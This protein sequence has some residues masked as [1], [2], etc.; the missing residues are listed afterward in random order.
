MRATGGGFDAPAAIHQVVR[1]ESGFGYGVVDAD[2]HVFEDRG[3]VYLLAEHSP[4]PAAHT[5]WLLAQ[6]SRLLNARFQVVAFTGRAQEQAEL[7]GWRDAAGPRL[8]ARWLHAPGGQGKTRLA[9]EFA[10]Q[11]VAAGWKVVTAVHGPGSILPPPGSQ[12]MRIGQAIGLLLIVD[13]AD[14]WPV[15]HLTWLFS[16]ALL[17]RPTPTRLLLLGRSAHPWPAVRA[18][19][20]DLEADTCDQ[21]LRPLPGGL[22]LGERERMF[23]VARDC[24][25][26]HYDITDPAVITPPGPLTHPSF[27][28][29]LTLHVAALAAVDAHASGVRPPADAEGLSAYLLD[30]ERRHW[31]R[32]YENRVEGLDFQTPP[33]AMARTV[34]TAALTGATTYHQGTAILGRLKPQLH[35]DQLL[36]D[37]T[38]CYPPAD[39]GA[40]LEPLYPDRLAEDFLALTLPGHA[41]TA[42]PAAAWAAPT[43]VTLASHER[44]GSPPAYAA[45]LITFLAAAAGP[46]RWPHVASHLA[47]IL[48]ADPL[49]A[50]A[51]G[52]GALSTLAAITNIDMTVLEAIESHLPRGTHVDLD[53][54]I[55]ALTQ[56]LTDHR[57]ATATDP[58]TRAL[59]YA[60]LS[61]RFINAGLHVQALAPAEEA[62]T[63]YRR[64][65]EADPAA[66]LPRLE[67]SLQRLAIVLWKVGRPEDALAPA[68]EAVA[69]R[70][71]LAEANPAAH[72]RALAGSLNI[73][74]Q[75]LSGVGRREDALATGEEAVAIY[76][77][78]AEASGVVDFGL[79]ESLNNLGL[80]QSD[81]GRG[82]DALEAADEATGIY[83]R[84][85]EA[86]PAAHLPGLAASLNNL[87]NRLSLTGRPEDALAPAEE[88][89]AIRRRLAEANPAAH[90]PHLAVS[91]NDLGQR[92]SEVGR[93]E[94][95]LATGEEAVEICRRLAE[96]NPAAHLSDLAGSLNALGIRLSEMGRPEDGLAPAEEAVAIY[97][98]LAEANPAAHL[99]ALAGSLNSLGMRLAQ[100]GRHKDGLGPAGESVAIYRRLAKA[101]PAAHL[102]DLAVSLTNLGIR[103]SEVGRDKDGLAPAG[104]A[105]A[106]YRRLAEANPATHLPDLA[107]SLNSL[108]DFLSG[109]GRHEDSVALAAEALAIRRRLAEANPAAH[110]PGVAESLTNLGV[111]LSNLGRGEDALAHAEEAVAIYRRLAEANPA[112][113]P[114]LAA[115]LSNLGIRLS[116]LGHREDAL[117]PAEEAVTIGRRLAEANPAAHLPVLAAALTNLG[118]WLSNLGRGED[119]LA[120]AEEAVPI[121]RRLAEANPAA[122]LPNLA[123]ALN[124]LGIRLSDL[125]RRED[126]LTPTD[127]AA[128]IRRRLAESNDAAHLP[129]PRRG[130]ERPRHP[131]VGHRAPRR[132]PGPHR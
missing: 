67:A 4:H 80:W 78:L 119:A 55:A 117:A 7:A 107:M 21:L 121:Y 83:R 114:G 81:L 50:I 22:N 20:H 98:R 95:A 111:W 38:S 35:P 14:R 28:L 31:T 120:H 3:P 108:G 2:L 115:A 93:R 65:S 132:R 85:A 15:S 103:L 82:E 127:E 73:L 101:Y 106:I 1:V 71:R 26:A 89:A 52:G 76:R 97:R 60:T 86:Y 66:Y 112:H 126:A 49:L 99:P 123:R 13:Y 53:L 118:V 68:E 88:A 33:G 131:A 62:V 5:A 16:N 29:V 59:L 57:L 30:R 56:R 105:V 79:A 32:L 9:A 77:Q 23:T 128:A 61:W 54:G 34:F 51:A 48:R 92:L 84:L 10:G 104:E 110:L 44:D 58:A 74:G 124:N 42:Y 37:H 19:L 129:R 64:L 113:L 39:Q 70:R 87:G 94:D 72:L 102:S 90:L 96:A 47:A 75:Q 25:A 11:S 63:I 45:R 130:S 91:L 27:G 43:T 41:V 40:V 36:A 8:S 125:G 100:V 109:L 17:H 46:G 116:D 69:I 24:F 12:D 18:T 6:P 122:H